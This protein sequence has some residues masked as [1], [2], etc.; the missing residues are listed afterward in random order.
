MN[1]KTSST[2]I[3][4]IIM[5]V[6]TPL[7]SLYHGWALWLLWNWFAVPMAPVITWKAAVGLTCLIGFIKMRQPTGGP[8]TKAVGNFLIYQSAVLLTVLISW[9]FHAAGFGAG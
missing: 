6:V 2:A 8:D 5:L 3:V 7:L 9:A 1:N 4:A